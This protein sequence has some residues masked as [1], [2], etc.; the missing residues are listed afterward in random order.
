[1]KDFQDHSFIE[2]D[3]KERF[4]RKLDPFH[5]RIQMMVRTR[6]S[7]GLLLKLQNMQ[8]SEYMIL[9]LKEQKVRFRYNLGSG[10]EMVTLAFVNVS[11][12]MW[13]TIRVERIGKEATLTV[14]Y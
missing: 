7:S 2:W 11:D 1:M 5:N 6:Q 14:S 13:H 12:G 8:K 9:E 3:F 10:E 4:H